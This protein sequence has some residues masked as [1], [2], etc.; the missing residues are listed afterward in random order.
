MLDNLRN[1]WSD[2]T[3]S[4]A[5]FENFE[6]FSISFNIKSI[7]GG[8]IERLSSFIKKN[9]DFQDK[10]VIEVISYPGADSIQFSNKMSEDSLVKCLDEYTGNSEHLDEGE[11][12][13]VSVHLYKNVSNVKGK[14]R[15]SNVYSLEAFDSYFAKLDLLELNKQLVEKFYCGHADGA[16]F[17]V[18]E[19]IE[20]F[21]TGYFSFVA[22]PSFSLGEIKLS[23]S[24]D[25]HKK[26]IK[27]RD[28]LAHFANASDWPFLPD[29]FHIENSLP[30]NLKGLQGAF[31]ALHNV[32]LM[33]FIADFTIVH[34]KN[35]NYSLRGIKDI[36][37]TYDIDA[38]KVVK[39]SSLWELYKWVYE[40][41][42]VD[43]LG[44][45]R[46]VIPLHVDDVFLIND[47]TVVSAGS[48]FR[49][50]QKEDVK[51]YIDTT[52][53]LVEQVQNSSTKASLIVG[54]ISNSIK[55]GLWT[56]TTF[57]ISVVLVRL[58]GK[59]ANLN[60]LLDL[61]G[62]LSSPLIVALF[63]FAISAFSGLFILAYRESVAEQALFKKDYEN[64]KTIYLNV[65]TDADINNILSKD[66]FF[67]ENIKY[68]ESKRRA[69]KRLWIFIVTISISVIAIAYF[70]N[71]SDGVFQVNY[72]ITIECES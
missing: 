58:L 57:S 17:V 39:T 25:K 3:E 41:N 15:Y 54:K 26:S 65:L 63:I 31:N 33:S 60:S 13:K 35:L 51:A 29:D 23:Y 10:I 20:P 38:L 8:D 28:S 55:A 64:M 36:S 56:I 18:Y 4:K 27:L 40:S 6:Y 46:N 14:I 49:L 16:V 67:D 66:K 22:K 7:G 71:Q 9:R 52:N 61:W 72:G 47:D 45:A 68:I 12:A 24:A 37:G 21:Q 43:K 70:L 69:Y 62:V 59:G 32:Y 11:T 42:T 1:I 19:D 34:E 5:A 30:E 2:A 48:S 44:I 53:K 50:S